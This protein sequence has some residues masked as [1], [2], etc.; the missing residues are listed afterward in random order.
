MSGMLN[1]QRHSPCKQ[2]L[3]RTLSFLKSVRDPKTRKFKNHH[4]VHNSHKDDLYPFSVHF[5]SYSL[6]SPPGSSFVPH[7]DTKTTLAK[8]TMTSTVPSG[9]TPFR[10]KPFPQF[11]RALCFPGSPPASWFLLCQFLLVPQILKC[12]MAAGLSLQGSAIEPLLSTQPPPGIVW[13][14]IPSMLSALSLHH[15]PLPLESCI[16]HSLVSVS[17]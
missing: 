7:Q 3:F 8:V 16:T 6:S 10:V 5:P 11:S 2:E 1:I 14:S 9:F 12:W 17:T 13:L 4:L 15:L